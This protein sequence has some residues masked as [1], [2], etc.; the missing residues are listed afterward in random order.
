MQTT[1]SDKDNDLQCKFHSAIQSLL[2]NANFILHANLHCKTV[3]KGSILLEKV[4]DFIKK[5]NLKA[6]YLL[7]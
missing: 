1:R 6:L 4:G 2:C 3:P 5:G 7:A